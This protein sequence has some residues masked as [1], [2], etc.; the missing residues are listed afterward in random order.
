MFIKKSKITIGETWCIYTLSLFLFAPT[1][2][3]HGNGYLT[4]SDIMFSSPDTQLSLFEIYDTHL[5]LRLECAIW[6]ERHPRWHIIERQKATDFI[7]DVLILIY[8]SW[9]C[10]GMMKYVNVKNTNTTSIS[11]VIWI[12]HDWS[13]LWCVRTYTCTPHPNLYE[14]TLPAWQYMQIMINDIK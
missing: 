11:A 10:C 5:H 3:I 9:W 7:P 8:V 1:L 2:L 12:L 4:S 13:E 14:N 6:G